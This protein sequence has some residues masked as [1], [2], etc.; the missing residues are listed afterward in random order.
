MTLSD[1]SEPQALILPEQSELS[2]VDFNEAPTQPELSAGLVLCEVMHREKQ[3]V[4]RAGSIGYKVAW[5]FPLKGCFHLLV[6]S[7]NVT[8]WDEIF[9][10]RCLLQAEFFLRLQLKWFS[11]V[12]E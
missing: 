7:L 12:L 8:V 1:A 5:H 10:A 9:H 11:H 2:P 6:T 3:N 4:G